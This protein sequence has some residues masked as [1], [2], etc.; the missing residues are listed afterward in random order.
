M[1]NLFLNNGCWKN[2]EIFD[3]LAFTKRKPQEKIQGVKTEKQSYD[4]YVFN[5]LHGRELELEL[6]LVIGA[7]T[8]IHFL[9]W[10]ESENI[11]TASL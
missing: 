1:E 3:F 10:R 9:T 11:S 4:F 7:I 5:L 2:P 6:G 8:G